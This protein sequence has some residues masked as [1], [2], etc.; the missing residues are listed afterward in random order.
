MPPVG[1]RK[2][3]LV[4][5]RRMP[6]GFGASSICIIL[7]MLI[8]GALS[9]RK[10]ALMC[11]IGNLYRMIAGNKIRARTNPRSYFIIMQAAYSARGSLCADP[12]RGRPRRYTRHGHM[13]TSRR[14]HLHLR[15]VQVSGR[16]AFGAGKCTRHC[17]ALFTLRALCRIGRRNLYPYGHSMTAG[18]MLSHD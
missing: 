11:L 15:Q 9:K 7:L 16:C 2:I 8:C 14:T 13:R 10:G 4:K 6:F 5:T 18:I 1:S 12:V 3:K 17:V